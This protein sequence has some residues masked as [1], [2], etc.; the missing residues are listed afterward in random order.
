MAQIDLTALLTPQ[1]LQEIKGIEVGEM[2]IFRENPLLEP[3]RV[4]P[5]F[6]EIR[7]VVGL[8][9]KNIRL[10]CQSL[11]LVR[12]LPCVGDYGD[13]FSLHGEAV[14]HRIGGIVECGE[15]SEGEIIQAVVLP[16]SYPYL[17]KEAFGDPLGDIQVLGGENRDPK[18]VGK[19]LHTG[20]VVTVHMGEED[21]FYIF[22]VK[23]ESLCP[24]A[25]LC[26]GIAV[27]HHEA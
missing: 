22:D 23:A 25:E 12:C 6:K 16:W 19:S 9:E 21:E 18:L 7:A 2:A 24:A 20:Y 1:A 5:L 17:L 11:H 26:K 3:D 13:P 8:E 4:W 10:L 27:V 15:H 14:T